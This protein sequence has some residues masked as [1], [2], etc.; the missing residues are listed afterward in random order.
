[1]GIT[2][3]LIQ[4]IAAVANDDSTDAAT[5]AVALARLAEAFQ[6]AP[7]LFPTSMPGARPASPRRGPEP[8]E[9]DRFL[10]LK[11][12]RPSSNNPANLV[13]HVDSAVITVFPHRYH[14]GRWSWS[15]I[16]KEDERPSYSPVPHA[17]RRDAMLDVWNEIA[18][19]R[20]A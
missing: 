1:M 9:R 13:R 16:R 19:R 10:E 14:P 7:E 18:P 6:R 15:M 12:W 17:S 11:R 8:S 4:K 20:R 5:R 3:E 2:R